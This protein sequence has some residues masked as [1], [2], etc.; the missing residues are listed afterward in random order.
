MQRRFLK[1]IFEVILT[2]SFLAGVVVFIS[3][4]PEKYIADA[5]I[6]CNNGKFFRAQGIGIYLFSEEVTNYQVE[7]IYNACD[8]EQKFRIKNKKS[9]EDK[10]AAY[11]IKYNYKTRGRGETIA[12]GVGVM[13]A[14]AIFIVIMKIVRKY[15]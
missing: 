7:R 15:V 12:Y 5:I 4:K 11:S 3:S 14:L 13:G 9:S 8:T 6:T 2:L 1:V 10:E